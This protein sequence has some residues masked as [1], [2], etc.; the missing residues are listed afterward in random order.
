MANILT[1]N[2]DNPII[3]TEEKHIL[4]I[5]ILTKEFDYY[6]NNFTDLINNLGITSLNAK[7]DNGF[8]LDL[9]FTNTFKTH[10]D[11][12]SACNL[13]RPFLL[14]DEAY[15]ARANSIIRA[16]LG[17]SEF[18]NSLLKKNIDVLIPRKFAKLSKISQIKWKYK[19][20]VPYFQQPKTKENAKIL[21]LMKQ[22]ISEDGS[23]DLNNYE[24]FDI[25]FS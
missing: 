15:Y 6:R 16:A 21:N 9:S 20:I 10:A 11:F 12:L 17:I 5:E 7:A 19:N 4:D 13:L 22:H 2:K 18:N 24:F 14:Q 8:S 25:Y 3:L 23:I 1:F